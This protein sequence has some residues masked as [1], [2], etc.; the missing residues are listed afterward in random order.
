MS[1][2]DLIYKKVSEE[3]ELPI[4]VVKSVYTS[5]WSFIRNK[6]TELPLKDINTKEEFDKLKTNFSIPFFG[7]MYLTWNRF[8]NIKNK[9]KY[10]ESKKHTTINDNGCN[11]SK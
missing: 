6:I 7:K 8:N 11:N 4:E 3:V 5:Y 2:L 9:Y 1:S 10:V